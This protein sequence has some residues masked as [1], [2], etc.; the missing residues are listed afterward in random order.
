M[1][2]YISHNLDNKRIT[3]G[4]ILSL[5]N[6]KQLMEG[7]A[8]HFDAEDLKLIRLNMNSIEIS[9]IETEEEAYEIMKES[10]FISDD[11]KIMTEKDSGIN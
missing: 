5:E 8:I 4:L 10:G 7:N 1:I 2:K 9:F 6:I 3:L 11:T